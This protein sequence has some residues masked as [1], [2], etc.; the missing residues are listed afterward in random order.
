MYRLL[1]APHTIPVCRLRPLPPPQQIPHCLIGCLTQDGALD[2]KRMEQLIE[3]LLN[4]I[5]P[6]PSLLCF[7]HQMRLYFRVR[8]VFRKYISNHDLFDFAVQ[9]LLKCA[10][11]GRWVFCKHRERNTFEMPGGHREEGETITDAAKRELYEETGAVRYDIWPVCVYSVS[12]RSYV[13]LPYT[14]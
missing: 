8:P 13:S 10:Y 3:T 7:F 14:A 11:S 9:F 6:K 5:D 2:L 1:P 12:L 4:M